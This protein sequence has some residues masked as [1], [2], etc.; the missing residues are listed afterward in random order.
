MGGLWSGRADRPCRSVYRV[1]KWVDE[2]AVIPGPS[3][4]P[5]SRGGARRTVA[6]AEIAF[7][8]AIGQARA[9]VRVRRHPRER[10][11]AATHTSLRQSR[12][13]Y[14]ASLS[15]LAGANQS[16]IA[17]LKLINFVSIGR[18]EQSGQRHLR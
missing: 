11:G 13:R 17:T 14:A 1:G 7:A 16:S 2:R 6:V 8:G 4:P 5:V 18:E 15:P 3:S 10:Y 9:E 12:V